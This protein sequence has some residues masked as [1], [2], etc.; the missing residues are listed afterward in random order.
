MEFTE[1]IVPAGVS[2][3][4]ADKVLAHHFEDVSRGQIQ[5]AFDDGGVLLSGEP[6]N[7]KHK[8]STGDCLSI[9][10]PSPKDSTVRAVEMPLEIV[11]ED[12]DIIVVNKASGQVVHPGSG[13]GEDTLVH[14]LLFHTN[15]G[16]STAAGSLRPGVVHRLDKETSGLIVFAKTDPAFFRL[17]QQ[18]AERSVKKEYLAL[19]H[20]VPLVKSGSLIDPIGRHPTVRVK[21]AVLD[22]GKPA[23][24]D[25]A[26]EERF[27]NYA[28][29]RCWIFTGRTHQIRVHLSNIHHPIVGDT[30]YGHGAKGDA[31]FARRVLLHADRLVFTH[32]VTGVEMKFHA[33]MPDDF[34]DTLQY[35][36]GKSQQ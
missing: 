8:V 24:T 29:L 15:G 17:T 22:R 7:K 4:R 9:R 20:G 11:H 35:L 16:L 12:D 28:L 14:A 13:T 5:L 31:P 25:W 27:D 33:K 26:L 36:R 2:Q 19:V 3:M 18:F 23:R 10:F 21:M 30:T 34:K 32:P 1:F 6:I